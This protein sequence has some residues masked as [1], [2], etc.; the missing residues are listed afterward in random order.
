MRA[1][2]FFREL[3]Q[4]ESRQKYFAMNDVPIN[5]LDDGHYNSHITNIVE[6]MWL[7]TDMGILDICRFY[8][9]LCKGSNFDVMYAVL[10]PFS[11]IDNATKDV[12]D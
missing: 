9:W 10:Y 8:F 11:C 5:I 12:K 2:Y 4:E 6:R 1:Y 3:M 7:N